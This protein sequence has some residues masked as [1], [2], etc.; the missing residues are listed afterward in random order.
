MIADKISSA[1]RV[2]SRKTFALNNFPQS[3][4]QYWDGNTWTV[5]NT[6]IVSGKYLKIVIRL[7]NSKSEIRSEEL[8]TLWDE[9]APLLLVITY[10]QYF[11]ATQLLTRD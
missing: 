7:L 9:M 5:D 3:G 6:L 8:L 1:A 10:F 11:Q 2:I 4:W